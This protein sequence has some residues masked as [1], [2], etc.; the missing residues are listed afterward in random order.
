MGPHLTH[1][2]LG[3][4]WSRHDNST[5][6]TPSLRRATAAQIINCFAA[7]VRLFRRLQM[8]ALGLE[9]SS[10]GPVQQGGH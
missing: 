2:M 3:S 8:P 1:K 10:P 6:P 4:I 7:V 9:A 5:I